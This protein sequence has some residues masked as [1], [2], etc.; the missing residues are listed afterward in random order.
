MLDQ[1]SCLSKLSAA[2]FT[3]VGPN[4]VMCR[5]VRFQATFLYELFL[6]NVALKL[7][8]L[9]PAL[10]VAGLNVFLETSFV[11]ETLTAN[12]AQTSWLFRFLDVM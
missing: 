5:K 4:V 3:L 8:H 11:L 9:F 10:I 12:I 2:L 7:F 6:A 1:C